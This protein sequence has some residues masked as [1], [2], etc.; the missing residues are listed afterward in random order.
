MLTPTG[1]KSTPAPTAGGTSIQ[2]KLLEEYS[3][4][5]TNRQD[6]IKPGSEEQEERDARD[7]VTKNCKELKIE[8]SNS[9]WPF[10]S[11]VELSEDEKTLYLLRN[12]VNHNT[13]SPSL[14]NEITNNFLSNPIGADLNG[15]VHAPDMGSDMKCILTY[16][17]KVSVPFFV[18]YLHFVNIFF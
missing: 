4:E 15:K 1:K 18:K 10:V 2:K 16:N 14:T 17:T 11:E 6:D 3:R 5:A 8:V 12:E 7:L 9:M 13:I